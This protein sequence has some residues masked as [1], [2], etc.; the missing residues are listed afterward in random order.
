MMPK[1]IIK[2]A[3]AAEDPELERTID[4]LRISNFAI[5]PEYRFYFGKGYGRGFYIAPFY[6]FVKF[7]SNNIIIT[8]QGDILGN[9]ES[10]N[11]SGDLSSN[12]GGLLFGAQWAFGKNIILDWMILGP[13]FGAGNGNF[14]GLSSQS[15]SASEQQR[16][17]QELE[18]LDIPLTKKTIKVNA[19]GASMKLDG[20]W[21]GVRAGLS[22]G[23][24]F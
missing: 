17:R 2:K 22:L 12:T 19:Q 4:K 7:K 11:L 20:P 1:W 23:F 16:V 14:V 13:H 3:V 18:N 24:R 6:R 8:Y 15:L 10:I 5:T 9:E 21:G